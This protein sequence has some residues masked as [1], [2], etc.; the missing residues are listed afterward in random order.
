MGGLTRYTID[1][2]WAFEIKTLITIHT[3]ELSALSLSKLLIAAK[4]QARLIMIL[5]FV[6]IW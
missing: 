4:I 6:T 5:V 3:L 2:K 1:K